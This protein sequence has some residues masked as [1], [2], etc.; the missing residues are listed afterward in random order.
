MDGVGPGSRGERPLGKIAGFNPTHIDNSLVYPLSIMGWMVQ[1]TGTLAMHKFDMTDEEVRETKWA[2]K[3]V[4]R[5]LDGVKLTDGLRI[6]EVLMNGRHHAM[7]SAGINKPFG[8]AYAEAFREWKQVFKFRQGKD[9]GNYYDA[10]IVC[11]QHRTIANEIVSLLSV[12]QKSEMGMFG[13]AKRVRAKVSELESGPKQI[14][15]KPESWRREVDGRLAE[16]EEQVRAAEPRRAS[17]LVNLLAKH[18]PVEILEL[19]RLHHSPWLV[20]LIDAARDEAM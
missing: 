12:K 6:G 8:K 3:E 11:A 1:S 2:A 10:A 15:A 17:E 16:I 18:E 19:L 13:L 9:A 20:R 4:A 5:N 14:K 7:K